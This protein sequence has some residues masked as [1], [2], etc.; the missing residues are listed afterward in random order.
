MSFKLYITRLLKLMGLLFILGFAAAASAQD[1]AANK[2]LEPVP[3]PP[4]L[5]PADA[6]GQDIEP[7]VTIEEDQDKRVESYSVNGK[8]YMIKVIPTKGKP[9]YL[10]DTDGD[11]EMESRQSDLSPNFLVPHWVLFSW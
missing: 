10:V 7:T 4:P 2:D 1:K 5:P 9:Y 8:T 3:E 11:G 6:P